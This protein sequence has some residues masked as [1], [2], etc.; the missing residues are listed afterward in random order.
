VGRVTRTDLQQLHTALPFTREP[1]AA[2]PTLP[3]P[4]P[5]QWER[6]NIADDDRTLQIEYV[7]GVQ[8]RLHHVEVRIDERN[9]EVTLFLGWDREMWE[10]TQREGGAYFVLMGILEWTELVLPEDVGDRSVID[11]AATD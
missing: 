2:D 11:G 6:V 1:T 4:E 3:K 5:N 8:H 10:K 9:I 7:R